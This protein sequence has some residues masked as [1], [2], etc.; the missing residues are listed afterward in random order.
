[1]YA[2]W[3]NL[4]IICTA[5][6]PR[7]SNQES[8]PPLCEVLYTHIKKRSN[9]ELTIWVDNERQQGRGQGYSKRCLCDQHKGLNQ[10]AP[11]P[12]TRI[13][14]PGFVAGEQIHIPRGSGPHWPAIEI[15]ATFH[16]R[17][18]LPLWTFFCQALHRGGSIP[19]LCCHRLSSGTSSL[20]KSYG[21]GVWS[22]KPWP[23]FHSRF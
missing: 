9:K 4:V 10:G 23:R 14:Q 7:G 12:N 18:F 17:S 19:V 16:W 21:G 1:M 5:V 2:N 3:Y 13:K 22:W 8:G 11:E 6:V 20:I 15:A